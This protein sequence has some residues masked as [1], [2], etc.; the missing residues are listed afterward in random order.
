[1]VAGGALYAYTQRHFDKKWTVAGHQLTIP[2]DTLA[3]ARG[4]RVA[5]T[6]SKCVDCHGQDFGGRLFIDAP[7]VARLYTANLTRGKGG[8]GGQLSDLDWERAI[9]H[10]VKPDGSVLLFMPAEDYQAIN[11]EDT[12]ALIA[13]LKTLPP[14]DR[15]PGKNSVGPI[16]RALYVKGDLP[17]VPAEMVDHSA[18]HP[19]QVPMGVTAEYGHYIAA[20]GG[21]KGCHGPGLSGGPIPGGPPE[22]KPAANITPTG[23]GHYKEAD[24][25]LALREGKRPGGAPIDTLMP[26]R[27]T[28]DMTDD[29]IRALYMYLKTVPPKPYGGR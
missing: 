22:W 12:G 20:I 7:P 6:M 14:V 23:I 24:F 26:F 29:E 8:V 11:D 2:T 19:A 13:Y 10:G 21:C 5:T 28:K 27:Y 4:R 16:G 17:L 25:F 1:L 3:L 18:K 15:E 9:R